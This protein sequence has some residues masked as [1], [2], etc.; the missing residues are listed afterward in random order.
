MSPDN[1]PQDS[2]S[3]W[4][5]EMF[6]A[7]RHI[8]DKYGLR[9][10]LNATLDAIDCEIMWLLTEL[11]DEQKARGTEEAQEEDPGE[12]HPGSPAG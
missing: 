10:H 6:R 9:D 1:Q 12:G 7:Q 2:F 3:R 4:L 8:M 5:M 11:Q